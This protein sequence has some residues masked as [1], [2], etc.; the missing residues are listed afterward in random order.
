MNTVLHE[1][2][3]PKSLCFKLYFEACD[4]F[5]SEGMVLENYPCRI[6]SHLS[7]CFHWMFNFILTFIFI[8]AYFCVAYI[9]V[10]VQYRV[11][12]PVS[13]QGYVL[14]IKLSFY[15]LSTVVLSVL[16]VSSLFVSGLMCEQRWWIM[17]VIKWV[18]FS[19][20]NRSEA[21]ICIC[22]NTCVWPLNSECCISLLKFGPE[23]IY[24]P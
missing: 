22:W 13:C 11:Q 4:S 5:W 20:T 14:S 7:I 8:S 2:N 17:L 16:C 15:V 21:G 19:V 10:C 1:E 6:S 12:C 9:S 23:G 24:S 18:I 3:K